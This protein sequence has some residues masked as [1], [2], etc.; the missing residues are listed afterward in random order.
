MLTKTQLLI[1]LVKLISYG[2]NLKFQITIGIYYKV[3]YNIRAK[4]L[5]SI[6]NLNLKI[7]CSIIAKEI[8]D[9]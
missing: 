6:A 7:M 3:E 8:D 5:E 1:Q 2:F 4:F 9:L